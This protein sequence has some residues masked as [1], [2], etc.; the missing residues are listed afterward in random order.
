[1]L[2]VLHIDTERGWRGGERQALWLAQGVAR[3]GHRS[4]VVARAGEPLADR[5]RAAGLDVI[6]SAPRSEADLLAARRLTRIVRQMGARILHAH[7]GHAVALAAL[8]ALGTDARVVVT[9]RVDFRLRANWG[10]RWKFSRAAGVIAISR[11]VAR[12]L[13]ESGIDPARI[14][15]V[16]S[17]IDLTR[18]FVPATAETLAQLGVPPGAPLLVQVAQLVGHKDP[19]TLVRAVAAAR[20]EVPALHA[21]LVGEGPLRPRVEA[22]IAALALGDWVH[23]AGYRGDADGLLAAADVATLSSEE[24]GLGTVLL[25]ALSMGKPTV[26]TAAG[27]IPEIIVD[28]VSGLLAPVHVADA[29]GA[30]IARVLR[31]PSLAAR[32]SRGAR[33]RAAEFSVERTPERTLAVYER[34]LRAAGAPPG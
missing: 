13:A 2:T 22:E 11:A 5:A 19:L 29:L 9:R 27:G 32:R 18:T 26:A 33:E 20:R 25:D 24:E 7:T 6:A 23:L 34:V 17:G 31:D 30:A 16:P 28:G 3:A 8:A 12:A 21:L 1:M 15:V 4:L 10:T 14:D